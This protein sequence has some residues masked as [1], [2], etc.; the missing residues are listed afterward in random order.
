MNKKDFVYA[1]S[2]QNKTEK[3]DFDKGFLYGIG[4]TFKTLENPNSFNKEKVVK[5]KKVVDP[6]F[7]LPYV[8]FALASVIVLGFFIIGLLTYYFLN[9]PVY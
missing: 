9:S 3:T 2:L 6:A 8:Y 5:S 7:Y 1:L 4:T